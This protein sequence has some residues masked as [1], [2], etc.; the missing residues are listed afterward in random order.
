MTLIT[1]ISTDKFD[2]TFVK[3]V[4]QFAVAWPAAPKG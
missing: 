4:P 3:A 2:F 1:L